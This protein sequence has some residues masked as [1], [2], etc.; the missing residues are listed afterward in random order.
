MLFLFLIIGLI[1]ILLIN[2]IGERRKFGINLTP[3]N[4]PKCGQ[5][6]PVF[7]QPASLNQALW[8]GW[9]CA[10]CGCEM[11]KW[12]A[13]KATNSV[14]TEASKLPEQSQES[15]IKPFDEKGR[16]PLEKVFEQND[17]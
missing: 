4:C 7:R 3:P 10:D 13:E 15:P 11:D 12:G 1:S 6:V 14:F 16:T 17:N 9:T 2:I 8:G 5:K